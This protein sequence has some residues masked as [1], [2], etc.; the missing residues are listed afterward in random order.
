[1]RDNGHFLNNFCG[2]NFINSSR[3]YTAPSNVI[4]RDDDS[5]MMMTVTTFNWRFYKDL[6][7]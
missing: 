4:K 3:V 5:V 1:M 6:L 2:T 7:L